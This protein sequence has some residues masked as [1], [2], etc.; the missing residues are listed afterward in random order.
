[1]LRIFQKYSFW[2]LISKK[3][4][5]ILM[6]LKMDAST[7]KLSGIFCQKVF[8]FRL[9]FREEGQLYTKFLFYILIIQRKFFA[10]QCLSCGIRLYFPILTVVGNGRFTSSKIGYFLRKVLILNFNLQ[11]EGQFYANVLFY[12]LIIYGK[13][14]AFQFL[15]RGIRVYFS[16][17]TKV[18]N[19]RFSS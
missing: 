8:L 12:I 2:S 13:H 6:G 1:M 14:L 5:K 18:K 15:S 19:G 11:A 17:L 7:T 10:F 9:N 16:I 4:V 3:K